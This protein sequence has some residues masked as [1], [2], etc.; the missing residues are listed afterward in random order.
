M[1]VKDGRWSISSRDF[2]RSSVCN[3]C[4]RISMAVAAGIPEV[5]ERVSP[6]KKDLSKLLPIIQG[7]QRE[8][9]VFQQ[10]K[11][12]LPIGDFIYLGDFSQNTTLKAIQDKKVVIAQAYLETSLGGQHWSGVADLLVRDDYILM[13]DLENRIIAIPE[14]AGNGSGYAPY[15]IKNA[16]KA[17]DS[18]K[19]QLGSYLFALS[20]M[21]AASSEDCGLVF[22]FGKGVETFDNSVCLSL[23]TDSSEKLNQ[24][25]NVNPPDSLVSDFVEEWGCRNKSTCK[26]AYCEYPDLCIET[27]YQTRELTL[28]PTRSH[29]HIN[30][31]RAAGIH[32]TAELAGLP[33]PPNLE[34]G[35]PTVAE[36]YHLAAKVLE[37]E[38]SG[39]P[40]I[41]SLMSG[42]ADIPE[43]TSEDLYFDIEWFNP[44]D[45]MSPI[46]FMFGV[47]DDKTDFIEFSTIDGKDELGQFD[48]FLDFALAR[49]ASNPAMHIF[50]INDPEVTKLRD[51]VVKYENHR[52]QD[53]EALIARMFDLQKLAKNYFVPGSA[54]YS[55][56]KLEHYYQGHSELRAD[57]QVSSGE[58]AMLSYHYVLEHLAKKDF[59][60]A[61]TVM[62]HIANYNQ[63][64]CLSTYL[65]CEWL[66]SL[67][68]EERGQIIT[69]NR[70]GK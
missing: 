14:G 62:K 25:L 53:V 44:V 65:F 6:H 63:K 24:I 45:S 28:L 36:Y 70:F 66:R 11:E 22:G 55:I 18:Y 3:H 51:L 67:D 68:F 59:D 10:L 12:S 16:S 57:S 4:T 64:D 49:F 15:D 19:L 20:E 21:N 9:N 30:W 47:V 54:S 17:K 38:L 32:T 5:L 7:N 1:K 34:K 50:H 23:F 8:E 61:E 58:D 69:A 26:E 27:H 2:F 43:K 56:K 39:Q 33:V 41:A 40:A 35:E 29:H 31:L 52:A 60:S 42:R 37:L 46:I 48:A 13:Q